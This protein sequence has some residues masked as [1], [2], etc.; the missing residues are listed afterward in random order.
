LEKLYRLYKSKGFT[1][2]AFPCNQFKNQEPGTNVEIKAFAKK[3]F[4]VTFPMMSKVDVNGPTAHPI[5]K[6]L[7]QSKPVVVSAAKERDLVAAG[8]AEIT[9][10]FNKFLVDATGRP[11]KRY[12]PAM[13][14]DIYEHIDRDIK[15]LLGLAP[16]NKFTK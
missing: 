12:P 5:W 7:K 2:I 10:N 13:D 4:G 16:R 6:F 11:I 14:K 3:K 8:D 1:V 15:G 9:W